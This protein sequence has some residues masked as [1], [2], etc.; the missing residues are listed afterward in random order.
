MEQYLRE[1]IEEYI[2]ENGMRKFLE[3]LAWIIS[4]DLGK[5]K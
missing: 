4:E 2:K 1:Q 5:G 3:Q